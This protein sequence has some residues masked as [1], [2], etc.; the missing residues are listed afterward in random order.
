MEKH[1][2]RFQKLLYLAGNNMMTVTII[3]SDH[4]LLFAQLSIKPVAVAATNVRSDEI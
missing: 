3:F 4:G 2:G 1:D